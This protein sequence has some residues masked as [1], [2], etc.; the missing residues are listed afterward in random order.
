MVIELRRDADVVQHGRHIQQL[1]VD[2][3]DA[4]DPREGLGPEPRAQCVSGDRGG[5]VLRGELEGTACRQC[6]GHSEV[7][8]AHA[9]ILRAR[10]DP[11][12]SPVRQRPSE[13]SHPVAGREE[14][15]VDVE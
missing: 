4:V 6:V 3:G 13:N 12:H 5:L 8:D 1:V 15:R 9:Y 14:R 2:V 11:R 10:G 7:R